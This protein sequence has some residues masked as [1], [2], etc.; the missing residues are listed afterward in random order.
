VIR[1]SIAIGACAAILLGGAQSA[2]AGEA[3]PDGGK[4]PRIATKACNAEKKADK[5]AFEAHW[6]EHAMRECKR[7][8]R[9]ALADEAKNVAQE[10]RAEREADPVAF[11][12]Q[13][14]TNKN[15][16]NAF[17]MCVSTKVHE[18]DEGDPSST[19]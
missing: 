18:D 12:E 6:G 9:G 15:G 19:S 13:Y 2:V 14:G 1:A 4:G 3:K 11:S 7:A 5:A 8:L 17:G 16:K 10:C